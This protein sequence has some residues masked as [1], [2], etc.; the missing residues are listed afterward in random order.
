MDAHDFEELALSS[1]HP[2]RGRYIANLK[3]A[4]N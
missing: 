1:T 4:D 3:A 2:L